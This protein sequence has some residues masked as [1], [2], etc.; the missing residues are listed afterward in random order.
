MS[1]SFSSLYDEMAAISTAARQFAADNLLNKKQVSE[2]ILEAYQHKSTNLPSLLTRYL[3]YDVVQM[4]PDE[5]FCSVGEVVNCFTDK[6][7]K[8]CVC[9]KKLLFGKDVEVCAVEVFDKLKDKCTTK[10]TQPLA[11]CEAKNTEPCDAS[12][13]D[14]FVDRAKFDKCEKEREKFANELAS[15][16]ATAKDALDAL[17]GKWSKQ[18]AE[19]HI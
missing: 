16:K 13:D 9:T 4:M 19:D 2:K 6:K 3:S 5:T 8:Q 18:S 7:L 15:C 14:L 1:E 12:F 10:L 17:H 11:T